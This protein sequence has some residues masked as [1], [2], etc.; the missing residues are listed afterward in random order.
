[1]SKRMKFDIGGMT[2]AACASRVAEAA[3]K[4]NGVQSAEVNLLK[5]SMEVRLEGGQAA[6][7]AVVDAVGK[8]GY[9]AFVHVDT[10][11]A[12]LEVPLPTDMA[13]AQTANMQFRLIVSA[14]FAVP[15]FYLSMGHMMGW[16]LP[17]VFVGMHNM[18]VVG[19]TQLLLLIPILV[20][21]AA[22]FVSGF[23]ALVHGAPTMDSLVALGSG[24]SVF[25]SLASL[26][27]MLALLGMGEVELAHA[28]LHEL[29]FEGAGVIV[30]L[31]TL[32]KFFEARAKRRTTSAI[33]ALMDLSPAR[34]RIRRNN[35]EV[36]IPT[37]EVRVGD[38]VIVR[39]GESVP[40]DGRLVEGQATIDESALTGEAIPVDKTAADTVSCGTIVASGWFAMEA[41]H[42][43]SDTT[44]A[45]I[46]RLVDEATSSKAPIERMADRIAG[47]FVPVVMAI[48]AGSF[49]VWLVLT[50]DFGVALNHA[51]S[52]LVI[53][54]PC[55]LGLATPTAIMV[56]TGRGARAGILVKSAEALESACAVDTVVFDKTGTLTQGKPKV[57]DVIPTRNHTQAELVELA[58]ALEQKSEHP[59]A[60]A[61]CALGDQT[62]FDETPY[63][64]ENFAQVPGGGITAEVADSTALDSAALGNTAEAAD[65][66][67]LDGAAELTGNIALGGNLRLMQEY[68]IDTHE[69]DEQSLR[70]AEQGKTA[71]Y[72]AHN[73]ELLGII[74]VVDAVKET[75]G[76]AVAQLKQAGIHT[77]MLTGDQERTARAVARQ[78]G[79]D[80]V[81]A[82][83]LP[84]QK[85]EVVVSLQQ[86]GHIVAMV[87]DGINDAPALATANVGVAIGAGTDIAIDSADMVLMHSNPQD[88]PL[89][90]DLSRAT[91][92]N[93]KQNMF[94]ALFYNALCIPIAAGAL[95]W[96]QIDLNPMIAAAAMSF[97]SVFVVSNALRLRTWKPQEV[98]LQEIEPQEIEPLGTDEREKGIC[99]NKTLKV[100]GM[101]CEHCV[102]HVTKALQGVEGVSDVQ[103]DLAQGTASLKAVDTVDDAALVEAI[104]EAGYEATVE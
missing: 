89:A 84:D 74:A 86:D 81:V 43:G 51:V 61:I 41:T 91:L 29:Y 8:A 19:L 70:L 39:A 31:I 92:R 16:P 4:V 69:L 57:S 47:V 37:E 38:T 52:V 23:R 42:V 33:T 100:E 55:A 49:A 99:M 83:V 2:C 21:N 102:M 22:Y 50:S 48:A 96:A 14:I 77:I 36:E 68:G 28:Y 5:N 58:V 6:I 93:I 66:T 13:Q 62:S 30:A 65:G 10:A 101:M 44:L 54:C 72:F 17:S 97:S 3:R 71:L 63:R 18:A 98:E 15:L 26:Y 75:S 56:G 95:S 90:M 85:A 103:V 53:S 79:V 32:G 73:N 94:W 9:S 76:Q 24:A 104:K 59:L 87:G 25:Y 40:V 88:V 46:I 7:D 80:E 82:Q 20:V 64:V 12:A 60:R 1:M 27:Q 34:A 78:I 11:Q 35:A 67:T 45:Q